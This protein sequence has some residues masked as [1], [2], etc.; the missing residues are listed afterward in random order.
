MDEETKYII[1]NANEELK[2]TLGIVY[3]PDEVDLQGDFAEAPEIRKAA[4][5]YMRELQKPSEIG[6]SAFNIVSGIIKAIENDETIEI[7]VSA[8]YDKDG[9]K[10]NLGDMHETISSEL[11]DVVECYCAPVDMQIGEEFIR[12]GTWMLGVVWSDT[13]WELV[14][15]G[16][17]TGYS[18]GGSG[19]RIKV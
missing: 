9:I 1:K 18:M 6:K 8:L 3:S 13:Q 15:K 16:D 5:G 2:Y 14:K 10:K 19:E 17:R 4:W 12:K 11:G 7:D